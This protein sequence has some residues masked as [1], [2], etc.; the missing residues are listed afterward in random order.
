MRLTNDLFIQTVAGQA[1][2]TVAHCTVHI[3]EG[4]CRPRQPHVPQPTATRSRILHIA[5]EREGDYDQK[6]GCFFS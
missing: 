6:L 4:D 5:T 1:A 3:P 2:P